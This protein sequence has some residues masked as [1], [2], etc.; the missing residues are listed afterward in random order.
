[1]SSDT[2]IRFALEAASPP[3]PL[4]V[5]KDE[6][7]FFQGRSAAANGR[8]T[9]MARFLG[10]DGRIQSIQQDRD[11][12]SNRAAIST[13]VQLGEGFL[14]SVTLRARQAS[15]PAGMLYGRV[16]LTRLQLGDVNFDAV[17]L[18]QGYVT[19]GKVLSWPPGEITDSVD[20]PGNLRSITGTD[21]AANTEF[22]ETVPT[23]AR[24]K[25]R[26]VRATLVTDANA[27]TRR[28][29]LIIDDGTTV[30]F[31]IGSGITTAASTTKPYA[32][33][34]GYPT[35]GTEFA[36]AMHFLPPDLMLLQ[37]WRVLSSTESIQAGD[38]WG[39]PQLLVEE[40][41]EE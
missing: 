15:V 29:I 6:F 36:E 30:L 17:V 12:G 7:L 31:R 13:N 34:P 11:V 27:A 39:A 18:V 8:I 40:W 4:Y 1:M 16:G 26:A 19:G 21:P 32:W 33:I 14:L 38:N 35:S 41:I 28:P 37:G 22:S 24:W 23:D 2:V 20:G 25:L 9:I 3:A 5:S 10:V